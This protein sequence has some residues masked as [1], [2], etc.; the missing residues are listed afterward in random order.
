MVVKTARCYTPVFICKVIFDYT[1]CR[2]VPSIRRKNEYFRDGRRADRPCLEHRGI[3]AIIGTA[4]SGSG[5]VIDEI[6]IYRILGIAFLVGLPVALIYSILPARNVIRRRI[7][8][9]AIAFI[10]IGTCFGGFAA[11]WPGPNSITSVMM[12]GGLVMFLSAAFFFGR[13][14]LP[15]KSN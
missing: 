4:C 11:S 10:G 2:A 3:G 13:S 6:A 8:W 7:R 5:G 14:F 9:T 1:S 15:K 12:L